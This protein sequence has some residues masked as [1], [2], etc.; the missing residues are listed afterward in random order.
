MLDL[1]H[2]VKEQITTD[3]HLAF[4]FDGEKLQSSRHL[5]SGSMESTS[6]EEFIKLERMKQV[7]QQRRSKKIL[8]KKSDE[9]EDDPEDAI[10]PMIEC[11]IE[12]IALLDDEEQI[13]QSRSAT[14]DD[15][16][17][18]I[19]ECNKQKEVLAEDIRNPDG[20]EEST[21]REQII[22]GQEERKELAR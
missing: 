9:F 15:I 22:P 2:F 18:M 20:V 12:D 21:N 10:Q 6:I 11:E 16:M 8:K 4:W 3:K 14:S 19:R 5:K 7:F 1:Y 13:E 17:N